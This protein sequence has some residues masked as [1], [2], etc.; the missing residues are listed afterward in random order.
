MSTVSRVALVSN[1]F[2]SGRRSVSSVSYICESSRL[3]VTRVTGVAGVSNRC[4]SSRLG[5]TRVTG[6]WMG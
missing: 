2:E 1:T 6:M 4:E 3:R 5:V